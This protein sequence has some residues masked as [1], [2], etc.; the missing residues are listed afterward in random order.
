GHAGFGRFRLADVFDPRLPGE[1]GA[2]VAARHERL[3]RLAAATMKLASKPGFWQVAR[4]ECQWLFHDRVALLLIFGVPLF[5]FV[6]LTTVFSRPVIRGLGVTIVDQ[7][8]SDASRAL[9]EYVAAS[10]SL[11]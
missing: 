2:R 7:D 11:K 8:R 10:P 6:V 4:R 1:A 9:V 3:S 5:A